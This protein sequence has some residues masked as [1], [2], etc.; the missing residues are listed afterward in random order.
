MR[1][2]LLI[3]LAACEPNMTPQPALDADLGTCVPTR[4]G[5]IDEAHLPIALG[6]TL[7]FYAGSNRTVDLVPS[8]TGVYDMSMQ[9]PNDTVVA[10]GPVGLGSQWYAPSYPNGQFVVDAGSGLDGIYHQDETALWLDG[11]AS[12]NEMSA[13]GKTLVTYAAPIALLRFPLQD[14]ETYTTTQALENTVVDGLPL[15]GSDE[16]DVDV[17]LGAELDVPYVQFS[18][19]LRVRTNVIRTPSTGTPVINKRT[20]LFMFECFGEVARAESNDDEPNADFTT[21]AYLRRFALGV[22]P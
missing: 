4:S 2:A 8:S 12:Q 7:T 6:A 16:V 18:P 11:T 17:T 14:G 13:A 5:M 1:T 19:I 22:N 21:A 10:I 15:Q 9:S 20:T 3:A